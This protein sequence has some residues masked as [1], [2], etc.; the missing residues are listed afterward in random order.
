MFGIRV[1]AE[2]GLQVTDSPGFLCEHGRADDLTYSFLDDIERVAAWDYV[3]TDDALS[4]DANCGYELITAVLL[5]ARLKIPGISEHR[6]VM[7]SRE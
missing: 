6:F 3:L 4:V 1:E 7:E 2:A 5:T